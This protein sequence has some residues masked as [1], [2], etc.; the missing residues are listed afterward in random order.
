MCWH[1][2]TQVLSQKTRAADDFSLGGDRIG[3]L[4][5]SLTGGDGNLNDPILKSSNA[6][7]EGM[8]KL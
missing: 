4:N 3:H 8:L 1:V 7:G 2:C 5:I 6:R